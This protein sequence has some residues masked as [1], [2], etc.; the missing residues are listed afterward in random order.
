MNS[1]IPII[2]PAYEPD[3]RLLSFL[4]SI[5]D[6]GM[7]EIIIVN[8]G[9]GRDYDNIFTLA[10]E[11]IG[12]NGKYISYE[13][14]RGKGGALKEAFKY[15]LANNPDAIG[16][17][18]ADSDGQH[19]VTSLKLVMENLT[20]NPKSLI[21]GTRNFDYKEIPWKSAFGNRL[22]RRLMKYITGTNI[23]D[24]Q[25]GLRG[26]PTCFLRECVEIKQ[27]RFEYEMEMLLRA[28]DSLE[29]VQVPIETIYDSKDNHQTHFNPLIDSIKIY[30]VLGRRFLRFVLSSFTSSII[31]IL[32]FTLLCGFLKNNTGAYIIIATIC[33][34]LVSSI[35]NYTI[36]YLKVFNSK[37]PISLSGSKYGVLVIVQMALSA[38]LVN[39][40]FIALK[41]VPETVVKIIVDTLLFFISYKIQQK[42]IFNSK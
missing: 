1:T 28:T 31:D 22:T 39:G 14:N 13:E 41:V 27:N 17:V 24:T 32:L 5:I 38:L 34:R 8:D 7:N 26:I 40:L 11:I 30:K 29:I 35:Y 9:S 25:T 2:I 23:T 18:T 19:T 21:L 42:Y 16:V 3:E 12:S 37:E 20:D 10:K 15:V 33:A 6:S 36:N 4:H